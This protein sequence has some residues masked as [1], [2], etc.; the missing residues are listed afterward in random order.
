MYPYFGGTNIITKQKNRKNI[1]QT[2]NYAE[3]IKRI[4]TLVTQI[5][6]FFV[7]L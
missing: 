3:N 4:H 1:K 6:R 2:K 5:Y 7:Q